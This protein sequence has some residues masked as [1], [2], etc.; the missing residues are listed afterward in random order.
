MLFFIKNSQKDRLLFLSQQ[1]PEVIVDFC[2]LALDYLANGPNEKKYSIAAQKL[3][4]VQEDVGSTVECLLSLLIDCAAFNVTEADFQ[5]LSSL[6]FSSE[7]IAI[8]WQFVTNKNEYVRSLLQ[9]RQ[10]HDYRFRDL[11]WRLD[12]R[13]ASRSN[14]S[15]ATPQ[16]TMKFHLDRETINE[17]KDRIYDTTDTSSSRKQIVVSTD[18]CNLTHIIATLENALQQSKTHRTR[19]FVKAFQQQ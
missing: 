12:A 2:K 11:E 13:V 9:S 16:I 18:P 10:R 19:N 17:H 15:Q 5:E 14:L 8:L 7:Q 6:K 1:P 4:V 3:N